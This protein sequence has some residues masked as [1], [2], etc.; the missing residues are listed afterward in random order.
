MSHN[1]TVL[2]SVTQCYAVSHSVTQ[3]YTVS[4]SVT[5]CYTVLHS[6]CDTW[7]ENEPL[8][9]ETKLQLL[10]VSHPIL[11]KWK[12]AIETKLGCEIEKREHIKSIA[13]KLNYFIGK[14]SP[15]KS[16]FF[17]TFFKKPLTPPPSF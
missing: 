2:H 8:F 15:T 16:A 13:L 4:H 6:A 9:A 10:F 12:W 1:V 3:C 5:Q 11:F 14:P 17:K 7:Q